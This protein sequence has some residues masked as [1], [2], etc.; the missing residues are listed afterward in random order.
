MAQL[1]RQASHP[2]HRSLQVQGSLQTLA[3]HV[4]SELAVGEIH[5]PMGECIIQSGGGVFSF[6]DRVYYKTDRIVA[7]TQEL[8]GEAR[9]L[10]LCLASRHHNG[11]VREASIRNPYLLRSS[12][13]IPFSVQLLGE[14]V[15]EIGKAIEEQMATLGLQPFIDFAKENPR[16]VETTR[17]RAIS[18]WDCY[19]RR[20][21]LSLRDFPC[22][23]AIQSIILASRE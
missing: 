22:Y 2:M 1:R 17:R 12:L 5:P 8:Q 15:V 11:H 20:D 23:R 13:V 6:P 10:A 7:V 4:A 9:E 18:Y 16:F 14:Y 19:Y 3:D 21:Y